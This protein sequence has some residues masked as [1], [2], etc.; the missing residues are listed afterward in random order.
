MAAA[1]VEVPDVG[2]F[3]KGEQGRLDWAV[4]P[5]VAGVRGESEQDC[6]LVALAR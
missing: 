1:A 3:A 4:R 6:L 5:H 2:C